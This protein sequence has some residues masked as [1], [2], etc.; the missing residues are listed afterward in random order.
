LRFL[1][2]AFFLEEVINARTHML[3]AYC[4]NS[5]W[6]FRAIAL[7]DKKRLSQ[8]LGPARVEVDAVR[9]L[10]EQHVNQSLERAGR[11]ERGELPVA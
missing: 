4:S 7:S 11:P 8:G 10:W 6:R 9:Q 5:F 3:F 1:K 2:D